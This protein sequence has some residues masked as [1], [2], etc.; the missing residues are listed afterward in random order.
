M[1]WL[2][3]EADVAG[4]W[5]VKKENWLFRTQN[6]FDPLVLMGVVILWPS[7]NSPYFLSSNRSTSCSLVYVTEHFFLIYILL[8][9]FITF[10]KIIIMRSFR[11]A[12]FV[13]L[14]RL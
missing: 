4:K 10:W 6:I 8:K 9:K 3:L 13:V 2:K 7:L 5:K 1:G 14:K 11:Y 12:K